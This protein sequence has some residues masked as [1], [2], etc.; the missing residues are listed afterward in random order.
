M[1]PQV[2]CRDRAGC[3]GLDSTR[4]A[5]VLPGVGEK[6]LGSG[7]CSGDPT[8]LLCTFCGGQGMPPLSC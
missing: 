6:G 4:E 8:L 2:G 1:G 5:V 7:L 3:R